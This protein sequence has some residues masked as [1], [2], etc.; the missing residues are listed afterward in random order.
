MVSLEEMVVKKC[1]IEDN[2][3]VNGAVGGIIKYGGIPLKKDVC[4]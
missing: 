1:F 3:W 2:D 4:K